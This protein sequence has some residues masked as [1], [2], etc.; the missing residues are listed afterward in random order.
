MELREERG[1]G[2]WKVEIVEGGKSISRLWIIDRVMRIG[3][4]AVKTGGIGGVGTDREYRM[5]G[6]AKQVLEGG[7]ELMK[8]ERYD[9]SFLYGIQDFY[10]RFGYVTCMPERRLYVDT[11]AAERA[12]NRGKV[13]RVKKE[14]WPQIVRIYNR[15]NARRTASVV[16]DP[17]KWDRFPMGSQ[18]GVDAQ[19]WVAVDE[20]DRVKG[21]IAIDASE[22]RARA[23]ELGGVGED[24][25]HTLL[26]FMASQAVK[27]RRQELSLSIPVDHPFA[28]FC[29]NFGCRESTHFGRNGGAMGRIINLDSLMEKVLPELEERW[30]YGDREVGVDLITDLGN[31]SLK[32]EQ[33]KLGLGEDRKGSAVRLHQEALMLLLMGYRTPSDLLVEGRIKGGRRVLPLLERLFPLQQAHMWWPDRF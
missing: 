2:E 21:Y 28:L 18:F 12:E 26:K 9:A 4:C 29:R 3:S 31:C 6:L 33:G 22:Q 30:G 10:H 5:Q 11:R 14:D 19:V 23:A 17:R 13:R 8:R 20:R 25:F 24:L 27:L 7:V 32:W 16:R 1:N 15:D